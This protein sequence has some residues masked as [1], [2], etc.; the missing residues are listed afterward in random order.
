MKKIASLIASL[1]LAL[2]LV[3]CGGNISDTSNT[4]DKNSSDSYIGIWQSDNMRF[5]IDKG[6][7]GRYEQ[8]NSGV[9]FYDFTYEIQD[10]VMTITIQSSVQDYV[11]SFELN[12][13]DTTLTI[14]HNGLPSFYEGETEFVKVA[15]E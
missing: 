5:T 10:E 15:S 3:A 9:G 1:A 12:D 7:I 13:D 11:A 8:P 4:V 14:L 6:G 2:V